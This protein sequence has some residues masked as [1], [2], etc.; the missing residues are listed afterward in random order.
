M[1]GALVKA[2]GIRRG[3]YGSALWR[4]LAVL[5]ATV[6]AVAALA[7]TAQATPRAVTGNVVFQIM[8]YESFGPNERCRRDFRLIPRDVEVGT[9]R[10]IV[11]SGRCGGEIRVEVHYRL[12]QQQGGVI[13]VTRGRVLFYEEASENNKDLDGTSAFADIFLFF[14]GQSASRN[15][16]VQNWAEGEPDDKADVTLTLRNS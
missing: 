7:T 15:I 14:P 13:R 1:E 8:D 3:A 5:T 9:H 16:H 11:L 2:K 4:V 10:D 12:E 6:I